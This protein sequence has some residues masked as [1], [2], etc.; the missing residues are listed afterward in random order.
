MQPATTL[1]VPVP[2]ANG[3]SAAVLTVSTIAQNAGY[4]TLF[5]TTAATP[6][7]AANLNSLFPQHIAANQVIVPLDQL[8]TSTCSR[9]A[10]GT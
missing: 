2:N 1:T 7:T 3:A 5:P 9:R 10:A 8:G 6:P 4:W